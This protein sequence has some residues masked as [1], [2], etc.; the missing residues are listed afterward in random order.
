MRSFRGVL[1][2]LSCLALLATA[3]VPL[4][5]G[6]A[7]A[8][9]DDAM[10]FLKVTQDCG[11][12]PIGNQMIYADIV[13]L[14]LTDPHPFRGPYA[15]WDGSYLIY[16]RYWLQSQRAPRPFMYSDFNVPGW[17]AETDVWMPTGVN[18]VSTKFWIR[19]GAGTPWLKTL[20]TWTMPG[21]N[22]IEE[23][24]GDTQLAL[25]C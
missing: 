2:R 25:T 12:Q 7:Q 8:G 10:Y 20:S 4:A 15:D 5:P 23:I 21:L 18:Q 17:R 9:S 6:V 22:V 19:P 24:Q 14:T 16:N 13:T 1:A 3:A 11:W